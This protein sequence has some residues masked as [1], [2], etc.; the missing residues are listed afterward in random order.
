MTSFFVRYDGIKT[1]A[2]NVI[3][4]M[5]NCFVSMRFVTEPYCLSAAI[6]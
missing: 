2:F 6:S 3:G 1:G 4:Y 5:L